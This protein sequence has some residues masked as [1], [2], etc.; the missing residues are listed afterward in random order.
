[1]NLPPTVTVVLPVFN[2]ERDLVANVRRLRAVLDHLPAWH[3]DLVIADNASTD[4]TWALTR[5]LERS[6]EVRALR[7]ERAGRGG[8]LRT[9]WLASRSSIVA[10]MDVDLATDLRHLPDLLGPLQTGRAD[11]VIGSRHAPGASVRR[12]WKRGILSRGFNLLA[13][14][15]TGSTLRDH[16]C[17]FKA[18]TRS[19]ADR[20]LPGIRDTGWFFDTELLVLAQRTGW[21]I[22]EIPVCW[23]DDPD[24]RV[25]LLPTIREDLLGLWRLRRKARAC[26]HRLR[27]PLVFT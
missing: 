17:G 18:L 24:S 8:A 14:R 3:W 22:R 9:A 16:Q 25:R 6:G 13:R 23:T 19:A 15:L 27:G 4:S 21:I 12:G 7:L 26:R 1:M 20:L 2:E 10:Y 11:V 5:A